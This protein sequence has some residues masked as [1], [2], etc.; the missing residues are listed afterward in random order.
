MMSQADQ[1]KLEKLL[2]KTKTKTLEALSKGLLLAES[3]PPKAAA[4]KQKAEN[5]KRRVGGKAKKTA[6]KGKR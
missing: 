5:A 4:A 6:T 2:S 3:L 1:N